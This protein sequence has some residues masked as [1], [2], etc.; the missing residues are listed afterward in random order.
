MRSWTGG[1]LVGVASV[2]FGCA[3]PP[4]PVDLLSDQAPLVEAQA[5]SRDL[6]WVVSQPGRHVRLND[7]VRRTL[8]A[9]PPSRLRYTVDI[10]KGARL[11]LACGI[12]AEYHDRPGVEFVVKVRQSG[13][14]EDVA[15]SLAA[16]TRSSM[17]AHRRWVDAEVDLVEVRRPRPRARP[18][19]ARLRE[20]RGDPRRAFWGAPALTVPAPQAPLAIVYLVDTLRADHTTPY[21]YARDTTPELLQF[22]EDARR[23]RAGDRAGLLDEAVGGLAPH[24]AAARPAPRRAAARPARSRP[25][26]AG[27]DAPGQGLRHRRRHR[28]LRHLLRGHATSS[29]ASTSSPGLHGAGD[30]PSKLVEAAGVVDEALRW[31]DARRGFPTLPLRP[32]H[33]PAR[34]LRAAGAV[35]PQVRA[36]SRRRTIPAPTRAATTRSRSTASA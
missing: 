26:H 8:P 17:P 25:R 14:R 16:R 5:A 4:R 29:R 1:V 15:W 2:L 21:G 30:R 34:A 18:G 24:V 28:Q 32:H 22:A 12:P 11:A 23:L 10:P 36:A 27:R 19:D 6:A 20:G 7:V 9:S 35:R 13:S 33:G 3:P 31:L